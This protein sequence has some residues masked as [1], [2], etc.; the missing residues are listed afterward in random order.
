M[1]RRNKSI[2]ALEELALVDSFDGELKISALAR[3]IKEYLQED[4]QKSF[5]LELDDLNKLLELFYRNINFL[6]VQHSELKNSLDT[7][8]DIKKFFS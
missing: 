4:I 5:D 1:E 8:R 3:W 6:K 7:S 2:R